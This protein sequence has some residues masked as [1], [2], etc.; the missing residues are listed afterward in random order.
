MT[1]NLDGDEV[2]ELLL[3][4]PHLN[5]LRWMNTLYGFQ[6][7]WCTDDANPPC[8]WQKLGLGTVPVELLARLPLRS[9]TSPLELHMIIVGAWT[10]PLDV[11]AAVANLSLRQCPAGFRWAAKGQ[12]RTIGLTFLGG[13]NPHLAETLLALRPLLSPLPKALIC[14][15]PWDAPLVRVLGQVLPLTCA[16]LQLYDCRVPGE[17]LRQM[18][19]SLPQVEVLLF[20]QADVYPWDVVEYAHAVALRRQQG[21]GGGAVRMRRVEVSKPPRLNGVGEAKHKREWRWAAE[22]VARLVQGVELKVEW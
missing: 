4:L 14:C 1:A 10:V 21:G 17:A 7:H 6:R 11:R 5:S 19:V 20:E 8:R 2:V 18:A 15:V 13:V 9:L 22:D 16:T 12:T 3:R